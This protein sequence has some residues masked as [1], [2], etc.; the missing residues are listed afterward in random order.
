MLRAHQTVPDSAVASDEIEM[1]TDHVATDGASSATDPVYIRC[2][3]PRMETDDNQIELTYVNK[4]FDL[5]RTYGHC[6]QAPLIKVQLTPKYILH[7]RV[8]PKN[9]C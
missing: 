5:K 8:V 4:H 2:R 7:Y 1:K 9:R 3:Q 6:V